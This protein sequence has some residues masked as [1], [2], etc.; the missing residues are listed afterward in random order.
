MIAGHVQQEIGGRIIRLF[1]ALWNKHV[2][3][4]VLL[5]TFTAV[6]AL[7]SREQPRAENEECMRFGSRFW[8]L[9]LRS[10]MKR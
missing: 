1:T 6:A 8:H 7:P 9:V 2:M 5:L 4:L 10:W 3:L